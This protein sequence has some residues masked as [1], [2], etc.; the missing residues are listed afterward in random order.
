MVDIGRLDFVSHGLVRIVDTS[1]DS[2]FENFWFR[3]S[4]DSVGFLR[5]IVMVGACLPYPEFRFLT[6]CRI[7]LLIRRVKQNLL[8]ENVA[9]IRCLVFF[10][11]VLSSVRRLFCDIWFL[12]LVLFASCSVC[13]VM[14]SVACVPLMALFFSLLL[15]PLLLGSAG[16]G[17]SFL[18]PLLSVVR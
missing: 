6:F 5:T 13:A 16:A 1:N 9:V 15:A 14:L 17:A 7:L 12:A 3:A 18:A 4:W 11:S 10:L 8:P 2:L